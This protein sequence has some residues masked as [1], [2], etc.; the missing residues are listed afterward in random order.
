M[1][2]KSFLKNLLFLIFAIT[3]I[4]SVAQVSSRSKP[5]TQQAKITSFADHLWY[6][7]GFGLS[8]NGGGYGGVSGNTFSIGLSPMVGYKLNNIFSIGPRL[9]FQY[10]NGR[11]R[12]YSNSPIVKF[13]GLDYGAGVFAR[14]KIIRY[15]FAHTELSYINRVYPTGYAIGNKLETE[16]QGDNQFLVGLGYTSNT[17][18]SSEISLLY[19]LLGDTQSTQLPLV[20]RLGFTYKF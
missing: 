4:V 7:G 20:Y 2:H 12:E 1:S 15:I 19:D 5:T 8:F 18:F 10:T 11:F 3:S 16:R 9:E 13:N 17:I 6:G 14:A